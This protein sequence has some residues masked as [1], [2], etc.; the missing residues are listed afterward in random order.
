MTSTEALD[1]VFSLVWTSNI[2]TA[3]S[4]QVRRYLRPTNSV[5]EDVTIN[6]L[7]TDFDQLQGG[8]MNV[9]AFVPNPEYDQKVDGKVMRLKDIPDHARISVIAALLHI[10]FKFSYDSHKG[11]LVEIVNQ[12]IITENEQTIINNRLKLTIK[13]I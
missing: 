10:L 6:V 3:I 2:K 8:I 9:N 13:N 11:I 5:K 4:G 1:H 12:H 7:E